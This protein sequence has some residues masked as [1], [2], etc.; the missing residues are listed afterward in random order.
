MNTISEA[1]TQKKTATPLLTTKLG[2]L[3]AYIYEN[4]VYIRTP[5][6]FLLAV[7]L[8]VFVFSGKTAKADLFWRLAVLK[9]KYLLIFQQGQQQRRQGVRA[10]HVFWEGQ[11][12]AQS[13]AERLR[14]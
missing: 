12:A 14:L 6:W 7:F 10:L 3:Q 4:K 1:L 8:A 13:T 2:V 11:D 5:P 9:S